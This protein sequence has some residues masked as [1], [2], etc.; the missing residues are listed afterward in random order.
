MAGPHS[1]SFWFNRYWYRAWE[2][3]FQKVPRWCCCCWSGDYTS[4]VFVVESPAK[5]SLSLSPRHVLNPRLA[6]CVPV[7]LPTDPILSL[8]LHCNHFTVSKSIPKWVN[9]LS[10]EWALHLSG[11]WADKSQGHSLVNHT[12]QCYPAS[13]VSVC[14]TLT[15]TGPPFFSLLQPCLDCLMLP[16]PQSACRVLILF[17]EWK[18]PLI[19]KRTANLTQILPMMFVKYFTWTKRF[20][21][22]Q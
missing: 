2:Y 5:S 13:P 3:V 6:R 1:Q 14:D 4:R 17:L 16:N 9:G 11:K 19:G 12:L 10:A 8:S 22:G 7:P 20:S 18:G 15:F 21:P